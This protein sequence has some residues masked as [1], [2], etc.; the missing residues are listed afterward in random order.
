M[1]CNYCPVILEKVDI[2]QAKLEKT[3]AHNAELRAMLALCIDELEQGQFSEL[4]R[5]AR[6]VLAGGTK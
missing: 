3:T 2:L 1:T 4:L 5:K 6:A